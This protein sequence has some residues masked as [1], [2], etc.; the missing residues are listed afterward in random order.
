M[1]DK[2]VMKLNKEKQEIVDF[3]ENA[4][5]IANPG[6]GKTLLLACKYIDLIKK[7]LKQEEILCL[8]FTKKARLEMENRIIY[9]LKEAGLDID[10]SKM[11]VYTF[12][13]FALDNIEENTIINSNL[14]RYAI[15][16]YLKEKEVLNYGDK[17]LLDVI[18]PKMENLIRYLKSFGVMPE[19]ID[20]QKAKEFFEDTKKES[21]EDLERFLHEFVEIF[22]E[23]E[24]IKGKKGCDY[25]DL[26]IK[27]LKI[28]EPQKFKYVLV[29]EL[30]DVNSMEAE[31]VL[32]SA[33]KYLAVGDQK[34]AIFGFQGGSVLNFKKFKAKEFILSENF[35]STNQIL[36]YAKKDF[37]VKTSK[38]D[39]SQALKGLKHFE[40]K[41]GPKP[42][43]FDVKEN[44]E[45]AVC[46][47]TKQLLEEGDK[48]VAIVI[49][50]NRQIMKISKE[51]T[52]CGIDYTSTYF[53]A[54]AE[55]KQNIITFLKGVFSQD[56]DL[57]KNALFTSFVPITLHDAFALAEKKELKV[58]EIFDKCP[59]Y[60][61][62]RESISGI[63]DVN[64]LFKEKIIPTAISYGK[65]YLLAALSVQESCNQAISLLENKT[66]GEV[67]AFLESSDLLANESDTEKQVVLTTIHK[68]KGKEFDTVIFTPSK[69]RN[70]SNFQDKVVEAILQSKGIN[71]KEELEEESIRSNFVAFT[72]AKNKLFILT[73]K[74]TDY[75]NEFA[76]THELK[77]EGNRE[78]S[79]EELEKKA[80]NLFVNKKFEEAKNALDDKNCW[81]EEFVKNH[82]ESIEHISFSAL[83]DK[84]YEYFQ[85]RILKIQHPTKALGI[86]GKVHSKVEA[87]LNQE[88]PEIEPEIKPFIENAETLI[89]Q[90]KKE[91]PK[92]EAVEVKINLPLSEIIETSEPLPFYGIIDAVFSNEQEYFIV[93][94]KT[95]TS[96]QYSSN[97]RQQLEL[98]KKA[99]A[100]KQS[101]PAEKIKVAIGYVG[102]RKRINDGSIEACLDDK[103]PAKSAFNTI[104]KK[105]LKFIEWKNNPKQFLEE[106]TQEKVDDVL[107][108]SLAE[109]YGKEKETN[110]IRLVKK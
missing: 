78:I 81:L 1:G 59:E 108:R 107:W 60:K 37:S 45:Q 35:R 97:Y 72:R 110:E 80:Y 51:M 96:D 25:A 101:I 28:K 17:Y 48:Q 19:D 20:L 106:L 21:K 69:T 94:W 39:Y 8:T 102:L 65:E 98:Y 2:I 55:A 64:I 56:K 36:D 42:V 7:G 18:V 109:Q 84:P 68:A 100:E 89:K 5:V 87:I 91:Y 33:E 10:L 9:F 77:I 74:P 47:L 99:F 88:K 95:S 62:I 67:S 70:T 58:E 3:D 105:L 92:I 104:S 12:H 15:Y 49:R 57:I 53:S 22:K 43:V 82:F 31:I 83:A 103:Q 29:D 63:E 85:K 44:S 30:Q 71:A 93:D 86:G 40:N 41:Q 11:Q 66:I 75:L 90:I 23:Y 24:K 6:T 13:S 79:F 54:S 32:R 14:L 73:E 76:E 38:E 4:L 26:L 52:K 46:E 34:Q 61:K 16:R 50:T 27:F